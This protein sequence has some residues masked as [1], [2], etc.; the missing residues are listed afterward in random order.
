MLRLLGAFV[1]LVGL[2]PTATGG[3]LPR[4]PG[5][6]ATAAGNAALPLLDSKIDVSIRGPIVETTVVQTFKNP[7]DDATEA[8][9]IFPLPAD[10]AVSAMSIDLGTRTI[11][12]AVER[13]EKAQ[14]RYEEAVAHGLGAGLLEQERPDV[15]TQTVSAI[16]GRGTIV[17]TLRYDAT[18]RYADG[19]WELALPLVVAPR[20]TPGT[21]SGRPTTG[22]GRNPDTERSPD[23]SRVTPHASPG[24]GGSSVIAIEFATA[25]EAVTSPTHALDHA[26]KRYLVTDPTSDHDLIVRWHAK[27]PAQGWVESDGYAAALITGPAAAPHTATR[28]RFVLDRAATTR[29]DGDTVERALVRALLGALDAKDRAGL[30]IG[31]LRAPA[32]LQ[33]DLADNW[34]KAN[35]VF[36]LTRVLGDSRPDGAPI[37]LIT[38]GLISDDGAAIAA[39]KKLAVPLHVIGI[40]PAPNRSLLAALAVA[41]GGTVRF[42][43]AGDDLPA[44]ARDVI[45]DAA[46]PPAALGVSWGALTA[47]EIVPAQVPRVG[48]GQ[49]QLVVARVAQARAA[50]ARARGDVFALAAFTAPAAPAGATTPRGAI[51]RRWARLRLDDLIAVGNPRAII[52]HALAWGLLSPYTAMVAL[53]DE[54]VVSGG[55]KHTRGVPVSL[56]AGM[57]WQ[58]VKHET[59]VELDQTTTTGTTEKDKAEKADKNARDQDDKKPDRRHP[60]KKSGGD[61]EPRAKTPPASPPSPPGGRNRDEDGDGVSDE[62]DSDAPVHQHRKPVHEDVE[63]DDAAKAQAPEP[64]TAMAGATDT[65]EEIRIQAMSPEGHYLRIEASLAGGVAVVNGIGSFVTMGH[66]GVERSVGSSSLLAGV[67]ASLWVVPG[68]DVEGTLLATVTRYGVGRR[69]EL[70]A[71]LGL[72]LGSDAGIGPAFDLLIRTRL[73]VQPLW[74]Y[75]RYDG[76]LLFHDG[77]RDGQNTGTVGIEAHF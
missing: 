10:A 8:T 13:R 5:M 35:A 28:C 77:V 4:V 17:V 73:P 34:G 49:A 63:S 71:G 11:R 74:L 42:A 1:W 2:A 50:N 61:E 38:D 32:D 16:P 33:R 44:L 57:Q 46:N 30:S 53:G 39:A 59:T 25:V 70:G 12:A 66:L 67:D 24:A 52:D 69:F 26:A 15:F 14:A 21:A 62:R 58:P 64:T 29:G 75:L 43:I 65:G 36:D 9:Y 19:T 22:S 45:S 48:A 56:P 37:V 20:Y 18:A 60:T 3:S 51:A 47:T 40:G 27:L 54:V 72:H 55:V 68:T 7:T 23:A 6:Y 31:E 41:T 76:A